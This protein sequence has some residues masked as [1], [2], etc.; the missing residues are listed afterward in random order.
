MGRGLC[1]LQVCPVLYSG[2]K[3]GGM[4]WGEGYVCIRMSLSTTLIMSKSSLLYSHVHVL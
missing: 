2:V 3:G 1:I 4:G